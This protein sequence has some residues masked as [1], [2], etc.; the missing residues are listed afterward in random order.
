MGRKRNKQFWQS[1]LNNSNTYR[2]YFNRLMEL[3]MSMFE[4]K[5][6]PDTMDARYLELGLFENGSMVV[7]EDEVMGLLNLNVN[8]AGNF[9]C[10]GNPIMRQAYSRYNGY[11]KDLSPDD[12]VI[13]WNNALR[14]NSILD[15]QM[16]A[17]RLY[18]LDRIIDVNVNAQK[19]PVMILADE[20]QR[21]TMLN[22][23]KEYDG[24]QP[25]IFGSKD[26]DLK[27]VT[28]LNTDAP[29]ISDK[30]QELKA[31]IWNE[32]LTYL[33]ISNVGFQKRERMVSDE[34]NRLQ[35]GA[36]AS[37][38]SRLSARETAVKQINDMFG[39]KIEVHY[40]EDYD[41]SRDS[42]EYVSRE[43]F[44]SEVENGE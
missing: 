1:L 27:S 24:N 35:G 29:Y 19:T 30:I 14:T 41:T 44:E 32:A 25:F 17:L 7:F 34:V 4:W 21:M 28:S 9:D 8:S 36:I 40:R 6:L 15:V 11:I 2:Q 39:T 38:Y 22:L 33:G 10:Y 12:S 31:E 20:A 42:V 26:L 23:Y 13:I 37:R 3:S 5:N 18:N 43:T 16:F